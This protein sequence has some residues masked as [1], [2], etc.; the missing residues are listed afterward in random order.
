MPHFENFSHEADIGVRG[1]GKTVEEA[2]EM[3]ALALT[4]VVT[5]VEKISPQKT[6]HIHCE[7]SDIE[8][9]F[10]DWM[11]SLIY[12]MDIKKMVFG[13]VEVHLINHSLEADITGESV[14]LKKHDPAVDVK[15]ATMTE[16]KVEKIN[17][18]WVAQCVVDV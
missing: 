2:F 18:E 3:A 11:N 7:D 5:N 14:D 12:E 13:K 10:Y 9:L 4:S 16:L 17:G 15:G 6:L 8:L 1:I